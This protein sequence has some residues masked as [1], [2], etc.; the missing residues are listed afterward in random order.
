MDKLARRITPLTILPDIGAMAQQY[1]DLGFEAVETG[2]PDCVGM[3]AG[4]TGVI[5]AT[6]DHMAADFGA[7]AVAPLAGRTIPYIYVR[8]VA[9]AAAGFTPPAS[10]LAQVTTRGG[11]FEALIE[12][13][14][15]HFI[16]AEKR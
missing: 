14:G 6:V 15:Q 11:T 10:V 13:E 9:E 12:R 7:A 16:L 8:S 5:L 4:E 3:L 2:E 1:R